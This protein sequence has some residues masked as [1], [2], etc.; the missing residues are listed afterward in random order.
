MH[1]STG[2]ELDHTAAQDAV[3]SLQCLEVLEVVGARGLRIEGG[4][5]RLSSLVELEFNACEYVPMLLVFRKEQRVMLDGM[6]PWQ[7][8]LLAHTGKQCAS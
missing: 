4:L 7:V 5:G 3:S 2:A 8:V 6:R 1:S